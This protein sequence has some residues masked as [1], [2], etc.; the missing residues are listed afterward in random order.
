MRKKLSRTILLLAVVALS[1]TVTWCASGNASKKATAVV[2]R[3][4]I[5]EGAILTLDH[6]VQ[7]QISEQM[8]SN[9]NQVILT[10][11]DPA[12]PPLIG[13]QAKADIP[14]GIPP[15]PSFFRE[16]EIPLAAGERLLR[17][18]VNLIEPSQEVNVGDLVDLY[19]VGGTGLTTDKV[20][21]RSADEVRW[22]PHAVDVVPTTP[23]PRLVGMIADLLNPDS[24]NYQLK[25][26]FGHCVKSEANFA[27][28]VVLAR[29]EVGVNIEIV[30][31]WPDE[32]GGQIATLKVDV[33]LFPSMLSAANT[34]GLE[35][36]MVVIPDDETPA[37]VEFGADDVDVLVREQADIYSVDITDAVCREMWR[38]G[39]FVETP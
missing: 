35:I 8:L 26:K 4:V 13:M 19:S 6:L 33:E 38:G 22:F 18:S 12:L 39:L 34:P 9:R 17:I 21:S 5:L 14:A 7:V 36:G 16:P 15:H 31:L 20:Y 28:S 3:Q 24:K 11:D 30:R 10:S 1:G 25:D 27:A 23:D 2:T 32:G 37:D 29:P